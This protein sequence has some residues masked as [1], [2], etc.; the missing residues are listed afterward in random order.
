[1]RPIKRRNIVLAVPDMVTDTPAVQ[2]HPDRRHP[3]DRQS[4]QSVKRIDPGGFGGGEE[5]PL[6][7]GPDIPGSA[8]NI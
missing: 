2:R 5:L 8:G 7:I 4:L 3:V 1:M 6:R